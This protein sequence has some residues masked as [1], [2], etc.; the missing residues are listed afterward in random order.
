MYTY[1]LGYHLWI[2]RK[3]RI[4]NQAHYSASQVLK[5]AYN[6]VHEFKNSV[7]NE[8]L[9][10]QAL[11][12]WGSPG[13][14]PLSSQEISLTWKP[15]SCSKINFDGSVV[16]NGQQYGVSFAIRNYLG[17]LIVAGG[18]KLVDANIPM[19]ELQAIWEGVTFAIEV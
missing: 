5:A 12:I 3:S 7:A 16:D 14:L 18:C 2:S 17:N 13:H 6:A 9:E 15:P 4:F 8:C 10:T 19:A 1:L 11:E